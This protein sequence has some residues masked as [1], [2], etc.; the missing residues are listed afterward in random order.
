M[1]QEKKEEWLYYGVY[2]V[3]KVWSLVLSGVDVSWAAW[4]KIKKQRAS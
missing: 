3:K 2:L 4:K 1:E